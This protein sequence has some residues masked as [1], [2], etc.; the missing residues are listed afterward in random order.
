MAMRKLEMK[1]TSR[2]TD[3][4]YVRSSEKGGSSV[5]EKGGGPIEGNCPMSKEDGI[6]GVEGSRE[7]KR[8]K[9][10]NFAKTHAK[11]HQTTGSAARNRSRKRMKRRF[12]EAEAAKGG[13]SRLKYS[14]AKTKLLKKKA[15]RDKKREGL[16]RNSGKRAR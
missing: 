8:V 7:R 13:Y 14:V 2:V 11:L 4:V 15:D 10:G 6:Q 5:P 12:Q 3:D 9:K 1:Q 16:K